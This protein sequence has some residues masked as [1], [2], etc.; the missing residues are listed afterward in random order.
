MSLFH[1]KQSRP[2]RPDT[3]IVSDLD[4]LVAKPIA[5]KLGG[6]IRQI[7]PVTTIQFF[8]IVN[9][10]AE[11]EAIRTSPDVTGEKLLGIYHELFSAVCDDFTKEDVEEMTQAQCAGLMQLIMDVVTGKAHAEIEKKK[12]EVTRLVE[13]TQPPP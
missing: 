8:T 3:D 12:N 4:A 1:V 11:L 10:L 5:F 2:E 6:K 7:K 13:G 9:R